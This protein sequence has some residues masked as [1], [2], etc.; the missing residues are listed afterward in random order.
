ME[1]TM[2]LDELKT[3]W[4]T[5]DRRLERNNRLN[6][7]LFRDGRLDRMRRGLRPLAWGQAIQ[8]LV[9]AAGTLWFAPFWVAHRN[10]PPLLL[11]GLGS[12][13]VITPNQTLT[14]S[15]VPV[16]RAGTAG[17][18]LQTGQRIGAAVGIAAVGAVFFADEASTR[19]Y[20]D[21]YQHGILVALA[22]VASALVI[23]VIDILVDR[24]SGTGRHELG[25]TGS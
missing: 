13:L 25:R 6:L 4:H 3:A 23:A 8:M 14:L 15:E 24:A 10:E 18:L 11:A 22:F 9:G 20:A 1:A 16:P 12:G 5:L 7:Q 19:N 2:D 21:A 17:G